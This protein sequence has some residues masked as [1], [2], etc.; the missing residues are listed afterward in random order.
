MKKTGGGDAFKGG[1]QADATA[2][3]RDRMP[4]LRAAIF[5]IEDT[6]ETKII[7]NL[8]CKM[9]SV[10]FSVLVKLL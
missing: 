9:L 2:L 1:W 5:E 8:V 7:Q 4:S 3:H 6:G 10:I